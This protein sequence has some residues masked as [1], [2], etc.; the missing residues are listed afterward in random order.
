MK[1]DWSGRMLFKHGKHDGSRPKPDGHAVRGRRPG[2]PAVCSLQSRAE[3][4]TKS[5]GV[6]LGSKETG[7]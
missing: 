5:S 7:R 2:S 6:Q 1:R 3:L 4:H